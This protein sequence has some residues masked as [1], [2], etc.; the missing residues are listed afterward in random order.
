MLGR[1]PGKQSKA[2][3]NK[4]VCVCVCDEVTR[5]SVHEGVTALCQDRDTLSRGRNVPY[6]LESAVVKIF[7]ELVPTNMSTL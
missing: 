3:P 5:E 2:G 4:G 6:L 1:K 7:F